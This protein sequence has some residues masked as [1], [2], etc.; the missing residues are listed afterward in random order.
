MDNKKHVKED[1]SQDKEWTPAMENGDEVSSNSSS[2][3]CSDLQ[4]LS[5][6]SVKVSYTA[7]NSYQSGCSCNTQ[8]VL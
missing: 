2:S 7:A 4:K 1:E 6:S 8:P 5:Q 3:T